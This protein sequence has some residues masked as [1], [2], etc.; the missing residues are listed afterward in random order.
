MNYLHKELDLDAGDVVSVTL[1]GQAN[2]MLL[3]GLNYSAYRRGDS[4]RYY[5]GLAK[6]SPCR[7]SPPHAGRWHVV[8]D[9]GGY[10]GSVRAGISVISGRSSFAW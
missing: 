2:V 3:D 6:V 9:L 4:F 5:G 1:T 10:A 7:L 8:V